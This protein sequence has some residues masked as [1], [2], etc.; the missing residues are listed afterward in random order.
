MA[1]ADPERI[2]T[3]NVRSLQDLRLLSLSLAD[4]LLFLRRFPTLGSNLRK[5]LEQRAR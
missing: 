5:L 3:A 1:A 4:F 2:R